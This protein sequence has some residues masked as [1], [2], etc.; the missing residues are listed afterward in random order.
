MTGAPT[1]PACP[2]GFAA[3]DDP[4]RLQAIC[5]QLGPGDIETFFDRWMAHIPTPLGDEDRAAGYWWE[6]SMRQVEVS[7]TIVFDA[8]RRGRAFFEAVVADNIGLGRP[9]EVRSSSGTASAK[10]PRA[11]SGPAW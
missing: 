3:V 9:S 6:L 1:S 4:D 11:R 10:T 2:N 5:D 7:R 8:P